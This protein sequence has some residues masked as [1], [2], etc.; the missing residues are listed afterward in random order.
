MALIANMRFG[1]H[2]K[3]VRGMVLVCA[4]SGGIIRGAVQI[5]MGCMQKSMGLGVRVRGGRGL[6]VWNGEGSRRGYEVVRVWVGGVLFMKRKSEGMIRSWSCCCL[7]F[8]SVLMSLDGWM[9][10]NPC[11]ESRGGSS[12]CLMGLGEQ[13][14]LVHGVG[15]CLCA[16]QK[17]ELWTFVWIWLRLFMI[18]WNRLRASFVD[19]WYFC[20]YVRRSCLSRVAIHDMDLP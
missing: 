3:V 2:V 12:S 17:S 20:L 15:G 14:W 16:S 8:G 1:A 9:A 7:F 4:S 5:S 6:M 18:D 10:G 19:C 13:Y 11:V